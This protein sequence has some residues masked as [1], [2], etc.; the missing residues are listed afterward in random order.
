MIEL[1][2]QKL[3]SRRLTEICYANASSLCPIKC[4]EML[5]AAWFLFCW[6]HLNHV[7]I[8]FNASFEIISH[9]KSLGLCDASINDTLQKSAEVR[10][11]RIKHKCVSYFRAAGCRRRRVWIF[12]ELARIVTAREFL[13]LRVLV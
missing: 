3:L 2:I 1:K 11:R 8:S 10:S 4:I 7:L 9:G 13:L 5:R 12:H 6:I